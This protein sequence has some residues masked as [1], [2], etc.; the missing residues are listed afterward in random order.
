MEMYAYIEIMVSVVIVMLIWYVNM[1]YFAPIIHLCY[2]SN[3]ML[4]MT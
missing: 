2:I 3:V 1:C 4:D